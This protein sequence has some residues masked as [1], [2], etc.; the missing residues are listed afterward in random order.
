M[1]T[2]YKIVAEFWTVL[3][4]MS[5]FLLFGFAVAGLLSVIVS[6][7]IVQRYLGGESFWSS[8]KAALLGVP[9]PLCSCG[10]IPVSAA[11]RRAGAGKGPTIA[12]L[13]STPQTGVDSIMVTY[14][15][16][17]G[18]FA[19][20]R[21][22]VA[23]VSGLAGG[24]VVSLFTKKGISKSVDVDSCCGES[25]QGHAENHIHNQECK[26]S[27]QAQSS[28]CGGGSDH[29]HSHA[30]PE[31]S[32]FKRWLHYGFITLPQDIGK[33]LLIGVLIAVAIT[34]FA[35]ADQI[36]YVG[37]GIV[38]ML[39]MMAIG[40]P[41][42]VCA[43]ASVPIAMALLAK[44]VSPGATLVFL[45]TGPATNAAS[46]AVIAKILG[47][48]TAVIYVIVVSSCALLAG[49]GLD[50]VFEYTQFEPKTMTHS[51]LPHW[52]GDVCGAI[53]LT[54]LGWG[55]AGPYIKRMF[56]KESSAKVGERFD[57][58]MLKV[59]DMTCSHC[60]KAIEN[61]LIMRS[62]VDHVHV[63]LLTGTVKIEGKNLDTYL[64]INEVKSLGFTIKAS[65]FTQKT[66]CDTGSNCC[67]NT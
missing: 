40:I 30:S 35:P 53:L 13:I 3:A 51:M 20:F 18:V 50:A 19:I 33:A 2:L 60:Q 25:G 29:A 58:L 41:L 46:L 10:V 34:V 31:G 16:M 48:K 12:F 42:Y 56:A 7:A 65:D 66:G 1:E 67:G 17:G 63:D 11:L 64:L 9:L 54:V 47:K 38:G 15:L 32:K 62:E 22:L 61:E 36:S 8:T 43:T 14:A 28:C 59:P 24:V 23:M 27:G 26:D 55:I 6:P 52:V 44:G 39:I 5:P 21:P 45:M 37:G 49:L 4:E 57:V